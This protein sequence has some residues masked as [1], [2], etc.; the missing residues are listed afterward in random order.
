MDKL[1]KAFK[2]SGNDE[3][4]SIPI[5]QITSTSVEYNG[6]SFDNSNSQEKNEKNMYQFEMD[7]NENDD[8]ND[9]D[10]ENG[11]NKYSTEMKQGLKARH[12]QI[13]ALS[14]AIGTGLFVG[15]GSGL[16]TCGPAGL[17]TGYIILSLM[18]WLVMNQ[19]AEMVS[20]IPIPGQTTLPALC[21]RYTGNESFAF[22]AGINLFYAQAL[23]APSE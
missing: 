17:F 12:I 19:I 10:S 22:A 13:I 7:N 2:S 23:I 21:L 11:K 15:S 16:A 1:K 5:H 9:I 3:G 14:G 4:S 8:D 20:Y 6:D 18:V